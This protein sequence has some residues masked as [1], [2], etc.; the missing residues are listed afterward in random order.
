MEGSEGV[1]FTG[2]WALSGGCLAKPK[3]AEVLVSGFKI[4]VAEVIKRNV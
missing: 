3:Q 4:R 1:I 2:F